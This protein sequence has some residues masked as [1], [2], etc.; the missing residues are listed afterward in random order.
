MRQDDSVLVHILDAL[1]V[2]SYNVINALEGAINELPQV[3]GSQAQPY[4]RSAQQILRMQS[5][6]QQGCMM[7]FCRVNI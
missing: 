7:N 1:S 6:R 4:F 2:P 3:S 5:A